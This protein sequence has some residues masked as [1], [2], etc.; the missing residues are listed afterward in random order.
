MRRV[1]MPSCCRVTVPALSTVESRV[2]ASFLC[3]FNTR[4]SVVY[5]NFIN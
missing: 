4:L 3:L 2:L 1:G 5:Q